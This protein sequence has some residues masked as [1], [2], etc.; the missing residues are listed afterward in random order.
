ME[1]LVRNAEGN[2]SSKDR[3]YA[4]RKLGK[5][6][7]YFNAA[8]K[9]EMVHREGKLDHRIEITVF[10]DGLTLRGE[11]SDGS[12]QAAIDKV[13]DKMENRLRRLKSRIIKSHRHKN[14]PLPN[15]FIAE[16]P[17]HQEE[18]PKVVER[19]RVP[20]KPMSAEEAGLQM[21]MLGHPFFLF[22]NAETD[23][24]EVIYRREDGHYG[25]ITPE[26]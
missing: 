6:D 4:A 26:G 7:R 12:I 13:A 17:P 9:V 1:L 15:G 11:E 23:R 24:L 18:E 3:E 8:Q 22:S 14:A 19:K 10:A 21:E 20:L 2:L 5:L 25:L 16:E